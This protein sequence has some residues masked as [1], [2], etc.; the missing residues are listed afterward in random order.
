MVRS[1]RLTTLPLLLS[2]ALAC[3]S[4]PPPPPPPPPPEA[5]APAPAPAEPAAPAA[6]APDPKVAKIQVVALSDFHGWLLPLEPKD[7][8]RYYGGIANLAGMLEQKEKLRP[9]TSLILDNG[10]MWT[11]PTESTLLRGESVIQ[12]YNAIGFSAANIANHEFDFGAEVLRARTQEAKFPFLGA[13]LMKAGTI[14]QPDFV[15]PFVILERDGV[16]VAVIGLSYVETPKTTLAKHVAGLE[17]KPYAETLKRVV[18][19]VRAQGAEVIVLLFHDELPIVV[20]T[21]EPLQDLG[22]TAVVAGQNHRKEQAMVGITPVVNPGPFGRS[23]VRFDISVD[24]ATRKVIEVSKEI[25]D[26]TGE[27]GAPAFPPKPELV[28]ITEGARQKAKTLGDEPL[29]RLAKPLPVGTF[30]SS[31]L[32]NLVVDSWLSSL[33][34]VEFAMLNHGAL[35]QPLPAGMVKVGDLMSVMPFENNLY[36]VTLTGAQVK[37]QL[38]IDGPVVGGLTYSFKVDAGRRVITSAVDKKGKPIADDQKYR[39]AILDFM[40]TGG[41]GFEFMKLDTAPVD[42]GLSWR[43]PVMRTLRTAEA[44]SRKVEPLTAPRARQLK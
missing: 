43:E 25:V 26:V 8:S 3:K 11:G 41:D 33:P 34:N 37:S 10:D 15:K 27:V 18:P 20:Q 29:G 2:L 6:P 23:Y 39:V 28:A 4:A 13:N 36:V 1:L 19:E 31:A 24:R 16:K 44:T 30:Q 5:A 17:F 7:F 22:I 12:A 40:Y 42:T 21:L 38:A 35:R 9:E 32:G 14:E